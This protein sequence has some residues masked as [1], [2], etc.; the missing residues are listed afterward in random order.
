M[1]LHLVNQVY[2]ACDIGVDGLNLGDCLT[3]NED[4]K[5]TVASVYTDPAVLVNTIVSNLFVIAGIIF[6]VMIVVS[7]F[8]FIQQDT[9][10]KDEA[11]SI[12]TA[13]AGGLIIMFVSYWIIQI[14]EIL[15]GTTI[16]F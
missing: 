1:K 3:L 10:G 4:K 7:G 6:F 12:M 8:K 16:L 13:A 15:T 9:K 11:K 2:A 14:V 5:T